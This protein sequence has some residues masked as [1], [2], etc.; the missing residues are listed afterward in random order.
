MSLVMRSRRERA[1]LSQGVTH[2]FDSDRYS[3]FMYF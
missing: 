2:P 1:A 3:N